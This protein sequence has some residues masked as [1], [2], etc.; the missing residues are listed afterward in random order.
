MSL[1]RTRSAAAV[2]AAAAVA[3]S[4]AVPAAGADP[5]GRPTTPAA[6]LLLAQGEFPAGYTVVPLD[7]NRLSGV[8]GDV[9][10]ALS[11]AKVTPAH[12]GAALSQGGLMGAAKNVPV[13]VAANRGTRQ[14]VSEA[15]ADAGQSRTPQR[16]CEKVH[17]EIGKVGDDIDAMVL[18]VAT[19]AVQLPGAP[20]GAVA[21]LVRTTG[22]ITAEGR[23]ERSD[24]QQLLAFATVRGYAVAVSGSAAGPGAAPDRAAVAQTL[25]AGVNKVRAAK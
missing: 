8:L 10:S 5:A 11:T 1:R 12:C 21:V 24:Q 14:A 4:V 23:T 25:T 6:R 22:T 20:R 18:D 2:F 19:T 16:G 15:I 3:A 17:V 9:G 7:R 13:V